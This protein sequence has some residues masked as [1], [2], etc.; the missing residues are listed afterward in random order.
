MRVKHTG[1][2]KSTNH[3]SSFTMTLDGKTSGPKDCKLA[4]AASCAK[5][6]RSTRVNGT[7]AKETGLINAGKQNLSDRGQSK[8]AG[9]PD[10]LCACMEESLEESL[11]VV[12][13]SWRQKPHIFN[14]NKKTNIYNNNTEKELLQQMLITTDTAQ[15][16]TASENE[17]D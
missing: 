7:H 10:A 15:Q 8:P 2:K 16:S 12:R 1:A 13:K 3:D 5:D 6:A 17:D 11:V 14:N 9:C 4:A